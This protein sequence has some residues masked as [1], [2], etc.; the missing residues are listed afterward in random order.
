MNATWIVRMRREQARQLA[1]LRKVAAL[2][3]AETDDALWLR[4]APGDESLARLL[5]GLGGERFLQIDQE[6]LAPWGRRVATERLPRLDWQPIAVWATLRLPIAAL[7]GQL[8]AR[9]SLQLVRGGQE[10]PPTGLLTEWSHW[11]SYATSAAEARLR[12]L[13]FA[14]SSDQRVLLRGAPLPPVPGQRLVIDEGIAAP[15]GWCFAPSVGSAVIRKVLRLA[16][17]EVALFNTD[18]AFERIAGDYF[19]KASRSAVRA[20]TPVGQA[21]KPDAPGGSRPSG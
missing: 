11:F 15:C 17:D 6:E 10:Q 16:A 12:S 5:A 21:F 9:Q 18:G 8:T 19:V 13:V 2:Q 1:R 3:V 7:P 14:L 4:S 20:S